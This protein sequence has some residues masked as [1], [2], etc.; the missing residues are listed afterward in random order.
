MIIA[1]RLL[2]TNSKLMEEAIQIRRYRVGDDEMS[3]NIAHF[4]NVKAHEIAFSLCFA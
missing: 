2:R 3:I 4:P 1:S